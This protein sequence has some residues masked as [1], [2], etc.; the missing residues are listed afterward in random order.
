MEN[1]CTMDILVAIDGSTINNG[2][3][4]AKGG[5]GIYFFNNYSDEISESVENPTNQRCELLAFIKAMNII[6]EKGDN[7]A[8]VITDSQFLINICEKWI[9]GWEKNNWIKADKKEV[10]NKD[11]IL[12]I[13][14]ILKQMSIKFYFQNSHL[15]WKGDKEGFNY[16]KWYGNK[17]ADELAQNASKNYNLIKY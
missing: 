6:L 1:R 11:L 13:N 7:K 8:S 14:S 12:Q 2:K 17:K 4:N 3:K 16:Q 5:L 9:K 10:K 15:D